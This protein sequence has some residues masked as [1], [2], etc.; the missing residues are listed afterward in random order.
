MLNNCHAQIYLSFHTKVE[1]KFEFSSNRVIT[2]FVGIQIE[3]LNWVPNESRPE[4]KVVGF[5]ILEHLSYSK[6]FECYLKILRKI[7]I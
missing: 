3:L 1:E 5:G 6:F 4:T 7:Q 2:T